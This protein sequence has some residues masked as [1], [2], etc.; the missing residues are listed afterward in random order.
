MDRAPVEV[1]F[2]FDLEFNEASEWQSRRFPELTD[3]VLDALDEHH[4]LGTVFVVGELVETHPAI[5]KSIAVRGHEIGLHGW[6]HEPLSGLEPV[7]LGAQL[8]R[9]RAALQDLTGQPVTGYRAPTFSLVRR[10]AWAVDVIRDAGFEYS[11]SVMPARHPLYGFPECPRQP[12]RWA[13]GLVELPCPVLRIPPLA[14]GYLGGIY[15]RLLPKPVVRAGINRARSGAL[16][17]TYCHP[18]DFDADEPFF[19]MEPLGRLG[20]RLMWLNRRNMLGRIEELH[21]G[22]PGRPLRDRVAALDVAA[23]ETVQIPTVTR[24]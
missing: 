12:F 19:V 21:E 14:L 3:A 11:S 17:W 23:L 18:Y 16:L 6:T 4:V 5:V 24:A 7:A 9:G 22:R 1:T 8:D 15:L 10:T 13:N 2:T 20:S